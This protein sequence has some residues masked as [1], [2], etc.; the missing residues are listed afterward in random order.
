MRTMTEIYKD[1]IGQKITGISISEKGEVKFF[2]EE[3]ILLIIDN[4]EMMRSGN[5]NRK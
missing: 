4:M 1:M 5:E 3:G 2:L